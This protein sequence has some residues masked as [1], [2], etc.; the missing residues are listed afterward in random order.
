M[1]LQSV[2]WRVLKPLGL[3]TV[4]VVIGIAVGLSYMLVMWAVEG[5]HPKDR[6]YYVGVFA[7]VGAI[8][9]LVVGVVWSLSQ[10]LR[11]RSN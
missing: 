5:I 1:W 8:A 10:S 2:L 4:G 11:R 7:S 6:W 3:T 9:G